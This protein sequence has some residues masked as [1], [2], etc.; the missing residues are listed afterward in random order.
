MS[1][2]VEKTV[3]LKDRQ[4]TYLQEMADK[5]GLADASKALRCLID[6]SI[7]NAAEESRIFTEIRCNDC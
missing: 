4:M 5:H 3:T 6:F 1:G 2:A 7:S